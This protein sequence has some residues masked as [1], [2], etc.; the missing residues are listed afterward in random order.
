M[1]R[2]TPRPATTENPLFRAGGPVGGG[3]DR[4]AS[5]RRGWRLS[6]QW[7]R[8]PARGRASGEQVSK[9]ASTLNGHETHP[10]TLKDHRPVDDTLLDARRRSWEDVWRNGND[11]S[12]L[13]E[14]RHRW[15][16]EG[17]SPP[18]SL[19]LIPKRR[20]RASGAV[21]PPVYALKADPPSPVQITSPSEG[22]GRGVPRGPRSFPEAA[23]ARTHKDAAPS[24]PAPHITHPSWP[25]FSLR[26]GR[27]APGQPAAVATC[28][29]AH[30]GA[31]RRRRRMRRRGIAAPTTRLRG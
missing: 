11:L 17:G 9:A 18:L 22:A 30:R 1:S 6:G 19:S 14:P 27:A 28:G 29:G 4:I 12:G 7:L 31:A 21:R 10:T 20:G 5:R 2:P 13:V 23:R 26:P 25:F 8:W 24:H 15:R 3:V 16:E